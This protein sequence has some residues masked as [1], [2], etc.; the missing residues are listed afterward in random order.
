MRIVLYIT[1]AILF[2]LNLNK[3]NTVNCELCNYVVLKEKTTKVAGMKICK[4]CF[5]DHAGAVY[6][7]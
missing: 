5:Y 3:K 7:I 1:F 6:G 2:L 4:D